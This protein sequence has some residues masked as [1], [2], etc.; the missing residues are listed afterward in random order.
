MSNEERDMLVLLGKR[1][2][3]IRKSKGLTQQQLGEKAHLNYKHIGDIERGIQNPSLALLQ[4]IAF[5]LEVELVDLF[6]FDYQVVGRDET[7]EKINKVL[8]S[9]SAETLNKV[10]FVLKSLFYDK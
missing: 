2:Q 3:A 8:D 5:G 7:L 4:S 6:L 10:L 9:L 1:I